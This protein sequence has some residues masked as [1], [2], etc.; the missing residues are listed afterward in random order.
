MGNG[1]F[2]PSWAVLTLLETVFYLFQPDATVTE[3]NSPF[4][5]TYLYCSQARS[6]TSRNGGAKLHNATGHAHHLKSN[7]T[8]VL[9]PHAHTILNLPRPT[10]VYI[11]TY[12]YM[13]KKLPHAYLRVRAVYSIYCIYTE[14]ATLAILD[15]PRVRG[16]ARERSGISSVENG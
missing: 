6:V 14:S 2:T 16:L 12:L 4:P 5:V 9:Y 11:R 15:L 10:T 13:G 7:H 1:V 3:S 8:F